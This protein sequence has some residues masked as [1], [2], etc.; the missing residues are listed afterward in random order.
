MNKIKNR[1][2]GAILFA[3]VVS[4]SSASLVYAGMKTVFVSE[5]FYYDTAAHYTSTFTPT[6][7]E[8]ISPY[9]EYENVYSNGYYYVGSRYASGSYNYIYSEAN[10]Y[11]ASNIAE[12]R[13]VST[14]VTA[15]KSNQ[16]YIKGTS[17]LFM[18]VSYM[19][20]TFN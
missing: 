15:G 19:R 11:Y 1:K 4:M 13:L 10:K 14:S 7:T 5:R 12:G 20:F 16:I 18:D 3:L 2:I 9:I 6:V 17:D 8:T